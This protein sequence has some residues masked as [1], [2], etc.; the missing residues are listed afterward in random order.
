V[1]V[2]SEFGEFFFF[3]SILFVTYIDRAE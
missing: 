3:L 2:I 1:S